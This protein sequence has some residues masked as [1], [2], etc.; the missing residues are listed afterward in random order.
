MGVIVTYSADDLP[1]DSTPVWTKSVG[2]GADTEEINPAGILHTVNKDGDIISYY[3][4]EPTLSAATGWVME[5][6][7]KIVQGYTFADGSDATGIT[8]ESVDD[9]HVVYV[10][11]YTDKITLNDKI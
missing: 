9:S 11:I 5:V 8:A 6:R 7:F 2:F 3:R 4:D 1:T 10:D